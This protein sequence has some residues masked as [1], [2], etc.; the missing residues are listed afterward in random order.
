MDK[1]WIQLLQEAKDAGINLED[2][3]NFLRNTEGA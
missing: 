1:D 2:I 3:K